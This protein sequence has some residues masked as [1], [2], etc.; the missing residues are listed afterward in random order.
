MMILVMYA[1]LEFW[2]CYYEY[3]IFTYFNQN[4][5][6]NLLQNQILHLRKANLIWTHLFSSL[7]HL[8]LLSVI[9]QC[10]WVFYVI[11]ILSLL[12]YLS[13]YMIPI[14]FHPAMQYSLSVWKTLTSGNWWKSPSINQGYDQQGVL[15][16]YWEHKI[17]NCFC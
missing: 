7:S 4:C 13:T 12:L 6:K 2:F 1:H 11:P 9:L 16:G 10:T 8:L 15:K 5:K 17:P 14:A 3:F